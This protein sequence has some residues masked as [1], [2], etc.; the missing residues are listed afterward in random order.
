MKKILI[1][2]TAFI[3]FSACGIKDDPEYKVQN[4][5]NNN[6]NII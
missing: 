2:I 6:I 4:A 3:F 5:F 1:I